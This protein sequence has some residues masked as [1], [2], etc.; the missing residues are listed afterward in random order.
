MQKNLVDSE[1][2]SIFASR[3]KQTELNKKHSDI[4][5]ALDKIIK[6]ISEFIKSSTE[7]M[8]REDNNAT[9][10]KKLDND[11]GIY[12]GWGSGFDESDEY[13]LHSRENPEY[14]A[15]VKIAEW[16]PCDI[17]YEFLNMPWNTDD[18]EVWDNE[19]SISPNTDYDRLA[20]DL[21]GEYQKMVVAL[22]EGEITFG[23]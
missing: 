6:E 13:A 17:D 12:V 8:V 14:C 3:N 9:Y 1:R 16:N 10:F 20:L 23:K 4:M 21:I 7:E 2:L 22:E 5:K 11:F 18:M 19:V 15:C